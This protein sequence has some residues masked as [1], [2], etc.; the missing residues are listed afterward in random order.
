MCGED[1]MIHTKKGSRVVQSTASAA[2]KR[3]RRRRRRRK[4]KKKMGHSHPLIPLR[5]FRNTAYEAANSLG[6]C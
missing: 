3:G 6:K 4:G 1:I 2:A 5:A